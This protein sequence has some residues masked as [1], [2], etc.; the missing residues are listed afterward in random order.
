MAR[1]TWDTC[2]DLRGVPRPLQPYMDGCKYRC[3]PSLAGPFRRRRLTIVLLGYQL[4]R[5][6]PGVR[7]AHGEEIED[8]HSR[9]DVVWLQKSS[10]LVRDLRHRQVQ[11]DG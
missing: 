5:N 9:Y 11:V 3:H 4:L 7:R 8:A 6:F 1:A 10:D 2:D